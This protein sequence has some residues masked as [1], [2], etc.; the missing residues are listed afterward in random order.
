MKKRKVKREELK[1][2][3]RRAK[4]R[5]R[6]AEK[7]EGKEKKAKIIQPH[8]YITSLLQYFL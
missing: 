6:R 3:K 2:R 4:S 8:A 5:K 7:Q 1:G